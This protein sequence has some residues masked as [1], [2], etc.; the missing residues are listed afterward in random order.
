MLRTQKALCAVFFLLAFA[1]LPRSA[2]GWTEE[3][4]Q[5]KPYLRR[6]L[7]A[8]PSSDLEHERTVVGRRL[9]R[10]VRKGDT[11][12]D[13][14]RYYGLGFEEMKDA[15]PGVD[16]WVPPEGQIVLLP[17]EWVLPDTKWE[18]IVVNIPEMRL[19]YFHP[20][21][22]QDE[23]V[24]VSTFPVGLGRTEWKTPRGRFRI[25]GK[26][27]NP[28]WVI[29]ES[30]RRERIQER[31]WSEVSI[32]GG[33]PDNPLGKHRFELTLPMYAIHGTNIPW[34]VG[35]QVSHGCIR[36]YPEDIEHLFPQVKIGTPG[37]FV[38]QPVKVGARDGEIYVEV[39][40]D[41]Y[42][43]TPGLY[44]E[45]MRLLEKRGWAEKIDRRRL[46]RAVEE[47][48]GVPMVISRSP[49]TEL[50]EE[51]VLELPRPSAALGGG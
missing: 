2:G 26:T 42:Q 10:Q 33:S 14:A 3:D 28:T 21:A 16:P 31:G 23:G 4:F 7:V 1:L 30:I 35:M 41:I 40:R 6:P 34:G 45:A 43:Y 44:R 5:R 18:G 9:F 27:V 46:A 20:R 13:L 51:E 11:F 25:R 32:P 39:H 48:T 24:R 29:P 8:V 12:L 17:T 49:E 19:Y 36:M 37:E 15:N 47:R 50:V 38:Y 22:K